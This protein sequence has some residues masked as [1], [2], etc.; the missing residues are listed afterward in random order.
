[1]YDLYASDFGRVFTDSLRWPD[2]YHAEMNGDEIQ[3]W[4]EYIEG[5]SGLNLTADM[6]ERAAEELG[7]FQGRLYAQQPDGLQN[8]THL[9]QVEFAKSFYLHDRS[10]NVVYE[11]IRSADCEIPKQ[12]CHML[13][14]FDNHADE[15]SAGSKSCPSCFATEIFG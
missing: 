1:V 13:I 4:M 15:S 12:L 7:R 2:C 11:Y 9:S 14:D 8:L 3:L 5:V 10:W 6:Y